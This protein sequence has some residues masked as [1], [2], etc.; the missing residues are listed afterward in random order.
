MY[1]GCGYIITQNIRL[2]DLNSDKAEKIIKN[3]L[4]CLSE[5]VKHLYSPNCKS[6]LW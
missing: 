5:I 2:K 3:L 4:V 1:E 6:E